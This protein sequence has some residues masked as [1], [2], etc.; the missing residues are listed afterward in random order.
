LFHYGAIR[1][2]SSTDKYANPWITHTWYPDGKDI[3]GDEEFDLVEVK[4]EPVKK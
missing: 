2:I 3:F 1:R 4:E